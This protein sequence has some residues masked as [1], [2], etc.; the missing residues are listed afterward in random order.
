MSKSSLSIAQGILSSPAQATL[1]RNEYPRESYFASS[2]PA[3][4]RICNTIP[5][6]TPPKTTISDDS[7][8]DTEETPSLSSSISP[9][10]T[11][12]ISP[13]P[14]PPK[15]VVNSAKCLYMPS[16]HIAHETDNEEIDVEGMT[17]AQLRKIC[18]LN[19]FL[20]KLNSSL[21]SDPSF[22]L[23]FL[24]IDIEFLKR[25]R[26]DTVSGKMPI[27]IHQTE[28]DC[29]VCSQYPES[30]S[31]RRVDTCISFALP[32]AFV[33]TFGNN[34]TDNLSMHWSSGSPIHAIPFTA[35]QTCIRTENWVKLPSG[36]TYIFTIYFNSPYSVVTNVSSRD[37][38]R[39]HVKSPG[40]A[41][42]A[43]TLSI[44]GTVMVYAR[45]ISELLLHPDSITDY[46]SPIKPF[47]HFDISTHLY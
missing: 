41:L 24:E 23:N 27:H 16:R 15:A 21:F 20:E 10:P 26:F 40:T 3:A 9:P 47:T 33:L 30:S 19:I 34:I 29:A 22:T 39:I 38:A 1:K 31:K 44:R 45:H 35:P 46:H 17:Y 5:S 25:R 6:I 42:S 18:Y 37:T 13:S 11:H 12:S 28:C 2:S 14:S 43:L 32:K 7:D 36:E 4:K 8:T